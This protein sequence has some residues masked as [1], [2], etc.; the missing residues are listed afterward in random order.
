MKDCIYYILLFRD[1]YVY[2]A[3]DGL[4]C[5]QRN[6]VSEREMNTVSANKVYAVFIF[7]CIFLC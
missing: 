1:R 2:Y 7:V 6:I 5:S 4:R 3:R